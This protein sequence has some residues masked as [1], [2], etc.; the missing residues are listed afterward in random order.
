LNRKEAL[1]GWEEETM[2]ASSPFGKLLSEFR[3]QAGLSK[4]QLANHL[5]VDDSFIEEVEEGKCEP[6]R[7]PEFYEQLRNVGF[8]EANIMRLQEASAHKGGL[9]TQYNQWQESASTIPQSSQALAVVYIKDLLWDAFLIKITASENVLF[10]S[11]NLAYEEVSEVLSEA[12]EFAYEWASQYSREGSGAIWVR[13]QN[14]WRIGLDNRKRATSQGSQGIEYIFIQN[15]PADAFLV[16]ITATEN[17][18]IIDEDL[19]YPIGNEQKIDAVLSEAF[20]LAE[21][22]SKQNRGSGGQVWA[23]FTDKWLPLITLTYSGGLGNILMRN[24]FNIS[25][26]QTIIVQPEAKPLRIH[27]LHTMPEHGSQVVREGKWGEKHDDRL[28]TLK[29]AANLYPDELSYGDVLRWHYSGLLEEQGRRWLA[30]PGGR[31]IPLV[32]QVEVAYL[33][34][35]RPPRGPTESFKKKMRKSIDSLRK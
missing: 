10:L 19:Y 24:A 33:K 23:R 20:E 6:P 27:Y 30:R 28:I 32:S 18:L 22:A 8:S 16:K 4:E 29:E 14:V 35:N 1:L 7:E 26:F 2:P 34:D 9:L 17:I 31:S 11:T 12:S 15:I 25:D 3:E 21:A 5:D 13:L